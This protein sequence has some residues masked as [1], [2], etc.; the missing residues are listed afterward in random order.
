MAEPPISRILSGKE[1]KSSQIAAYTFAPVAL[2]SP[3]FALVPKVERSA[4]GTLLLPETL[5]SPLRIK[6]IKLPVQHP[7]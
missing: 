4:L 2:V 5:F 6:C 7:P 3:S 1:V